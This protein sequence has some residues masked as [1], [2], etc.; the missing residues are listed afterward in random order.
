MNI[1]IDGVQVAEA[2]TDEKGHYISEMRV[3]WNSTLETKKFRVGVPSKDVWSD[4][5]TV[6]VKKWK[7]RIKVTSHKKYY[8][9]EKIRLKGDFSTDAPIDKS[10]IELNSTIEDIKNIKR[11]GSFKL[12]I[13]SD[14]FSWG[15]NNI[16]FTYSGNETILSSSYTVEFKRNIPTALKLETKKSGRYDL[17]K[18]LPLRGILLNK[19]F[20]EG[21]GGMNISILID[22]NIVKEVTTLENGSYYL[23]LDINELDLQKGNHKIKAVFEGTLI[24]RKSESENLNIYIS[25]NGYIIDDGDDDN[26]DDDDDDKIFGVVEKYDLIL[27][28]FIAVMSAL[29]AYVYHKLKHREVKVSETEEEQKEEGPF[30]YEKEPVLTRVED[31]NEI[32]Y[33]YGHL[34]N[35]LQDKGIIEV[36]K[37]KTH[38]DL[39]KDISDRIGL[40]EE[41]RKITDIFEKAYFTDRQISV[42][43]IETFNQSLS[44]VE[45]EALL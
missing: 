44:E 4:N 39:L 32:S 37:G 33:V 8:F 35:N 20:D 18:P 40:H 22:G 41:L 30:E 5:H 11:N 26:G 27:L 28:I 2:I 34:I 10:T 25:D 14:T 36:K 23:E 15:S 24:F 45:K 13:D 3:P 9:D 29:T 16:S 38:R 31:R 1:H 7:S 6:D 21:I 12:E 42:S 19:T 17:D 43:E